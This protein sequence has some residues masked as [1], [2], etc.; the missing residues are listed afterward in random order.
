MT[1]RTDDRKRFDE[2]RVGKLR[3]MALYAIAVVGI[4][5]CLQ[6]ALM[7]VLA[8]TAPHYDTI[9]GAS[10]Q[11]E[12][13]AK[14]IART[15]S[16]GDVA[17]VRSLSTN[18]NDLN[19][20]EQAEWERFAAGG[21]GDAII[22]TF[23]AKTRAHIAAGEALR[24]QITAESIGSNLLLL[25]SAIG[26][27]FLVVR[28][29]VDGFTG[30]IAVEKLQ[31]DRLRSASALAFAQSGNIGEK[32]DET[33]AFSAETLGVE[34]AL[35]GVV[36]GDALEAIHGAGKDYTVGQTLPLR[37]TV[38]QGAFGSRAVLAWHDLA[39]EPWAVEAGYHRTY[40]CVAAT[41]L[42][43]DD[44]A[45]GTVSFF[46]REARSHEFTRSDREFV[47]IV[48]SFVGNAM[49]RERRERKLSEKAYADPLTQLP[50]RAFFLDR[51]AD[52]LLHAHR[53]GDQLSVQFVDLDGFKAVNDRLGH[54]AGDEVLRMVA[55]R[56]GAALRDED[57]LARMGGDE[58]AVLQR[59]CRDEGDALQLGQRL[60][61]AA[62]QPMLIEGESV[63]IGA[64]V[65]I[66]RYPSDASNGEG[67]IE[68]ADH[69]MYAAKRGGKNAA[70]LYEPGLAQPPGTVAGG[71]R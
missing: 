18:L 52:V 2:A 45:A 58:F 30:L 20:N 1:K 49:E 51:L 48:A 19:A 65:G 6:L 9:V 47:R 17:Q 57:L 7:V 68:C 16:A 41:T 62:S 59:S 36:R 29:A 66:A 27:L 61:V 46:S 23:A 13:L 5:A 28:P 31:R 24:V 70:V 67:L 10:A 32:I 3:A 71:N 26:L 60:V 11:R 55:A 50:N 42:Y 21:N 4:V 40:R 34:T 15:R 56:M 69:A 14:N 8:N 12:T 64:S 63:R 25:G 44:E 53:E 38:V 39:N 54:A 33:L 22:R 35:V 37:D 43:L